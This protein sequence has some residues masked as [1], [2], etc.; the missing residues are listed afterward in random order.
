MCAKLG[1]VPRSYRRS[2]F[3]VKLAQALAKYIVIH[4]KE[5]IMSLF[6]KLWNNHPTITDDDYPCSSNG[7]KNFPNQCAIRMGEC[8]ERSGIKTQ[9]LPVRR[10]WFHKD[11][12]GHRV[13]SQY[14]V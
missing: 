12:P 9:I 5:E 2:A 8:F 7:K 4:Y 13:R 14:D 1:E 10:C 6:E 11:Q 3:C